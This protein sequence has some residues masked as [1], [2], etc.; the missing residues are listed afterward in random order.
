MIPPAL[1]LAGI[2]KR[3]G[4]VD[5]LRGVDLA[6]HEGEIHALLGENGAGKSTLVHVAYGLVR[7][8][9]GQV[10]VR[11]RR[12]SLRSPRDARRY[13]IGMVHQHFTSIPAFS[14]AENVALAAGWKVVP[15]VVRERVTALSEATGLALDP[16]LRAGR[17][18]VALKQRL[19]IVKALASEQRI[20]LLDEP[21]AVLPPAEA[22]ELLRVM[23][24]L[25]RAGG[26]ALLIT[27]KLD[28]ALRIADRITVLRQ[29]AVTL[30]GPAASQTP[31][32]L[33]E[34]M[35]GPAGETLVE[36]PA[37][38][39]GHVAPAGPVLVRVAAL[40]LPRESG[41]GLAVREAEL[42]AHGGEIVGVAGVEGSGHREL[43]RA[44]AG[45]LH[46]LRGRLE[47]TGPVGFVPE[48]RT[49]EGLIL[50]FTLTEN[51][52]LGYGGDAPWMRGR[53]RRIDWAVARARTAELLARFGVRAA[54]PDVRAFTL[55]GGNQQKLVIAREMAR[56][57]K[58]LVA[59]NPTRGLDVQSA[60]AVHA[61]LR[62]AAAAGAAVLVHST[63]LDEV[64]A[65][66]DRTIVVAGGAVLE[67]PAGAARTEVGE[68]MLRGRLAR[69]G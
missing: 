8:D 61:R 36:I 33:A 27:H 16:D 2:T 17:L 15:R 54:G 22:E 57:P 66:A 67:V 68:L 4:T 48:D 59:E 53:G 11:G 19:E 26:A 44:I 51:L 12:V 62:E 20:L 32:S 35:V 64:L 60:A 50:D 10:R 37:R 3:F 1:E 39:A 9:T 55:S 30:H 45:R 69:A 34:A 13:G 18:S 14:V 49:T 47:V 40:D 38:E 56:A 43:L 52:V 7:P 42:T 31:R 5:A 29:G 25:V 23:R 46:P 6:V 28:E 58:V 63:D 65:L 24:E 41:Y 21:T